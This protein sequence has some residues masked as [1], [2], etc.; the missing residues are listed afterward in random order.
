MINADSKSG[1]IKQETSALL[2]GN[3]L[4]KYYNLLGLDKDEILA[5]E[6]LLNSQKN[7]LKPFLALF[8]F[9]TN[10]LYSN[11]KIQVKD[12]LEFALNHP[13]VQ[14]WLS[15]YPTSRIYYNTWD[16]KKAVVLARKIPLT[17]NI[18]HPHLGISYSK[19]DQILL[20]ALEGDLEIVVTPDRDDKYSINCRIS[21]PNYEPIVFS[22][23]G[24]HSYQISIDNKPFLPIEFKTII[25][26]VPF[27]KYMENSISEKWKFKIINME[28]SSFS[29]SNTHMGF[30][31]KSNNFQRLL[32]G[33]L[34]TVFV[35]NVATAS[36]CC[37]LESES[38]SSKMT[39]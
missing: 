5:I 32:V 28:F 12:N 35:L 17:L 9:T 36:T 13:Q 11:V 25:S 8:Q 7:W 23:I 18:L 29:V 31:R 37:D 34:L 24:I 4:N 26:V 10:I 30:L 19:L 38:A 14:N 15:R 2:I 20:E 3:I 27:I 6:D 39:T 1:S 33:L 21:I 22:T 16:A